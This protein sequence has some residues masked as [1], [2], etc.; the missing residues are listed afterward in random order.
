V[1]RCLHVI[2][3]CVG[4]SVELIIALGAAKRHA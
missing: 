2:S 3:G 4:W 1:Y